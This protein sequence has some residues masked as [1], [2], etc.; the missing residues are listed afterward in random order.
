MTIIIEFLPN[1]KQKVLELS[2]E[3]GY[4]VIKLDSESYLLIHYTIDGNTYEVLQ[5]NELTKK[6]SDYYQVKQNE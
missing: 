3:Q 1:G 6:L 4:Q 2:I 5:R